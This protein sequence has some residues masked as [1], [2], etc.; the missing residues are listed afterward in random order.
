[1]ILTALDIETLGLIP[2]D[3]GVCEIGHCRVTFDGM[4]PT[5]G[6]PWGV[7]V[8][9]HQPIPPTA[10]GGSPEVLSA[11]DTGERKF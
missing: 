6:L 7:L 8:N 11:M 3:G 2:A 4:T 1:M 10:S 5:V 9:P